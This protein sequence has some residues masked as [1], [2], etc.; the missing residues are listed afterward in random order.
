MSLAAEIR[1]SASA[2]RAA[3]PILAV[4][5]RPLVRAGLARLAGSALD[6]KVEAVVDLAEA[7]SVLRAVATGPRALFIGVRRGEDAARLVGEALRFGVPVICAIDG[8]DEAAARAALAAGADDCLVIERAEGESLRATVR[9][10]ESG[11]W[12]PP[13]VGPAGETQPARTATVTE[14]SLEVLGSLA[15]GLHDHEIALRLGI[16]TSSVRKHI[17]GAQARLSARTRTQAVA[18]A[19][20]EGLL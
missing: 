11:D 13:A 19:A 5:R 10:I 9:A 8:E 15:D 18:V 7:D 1:F 16:S 20:R 2:D 14:R 3:G 4:D 6:C 17:A 12:T